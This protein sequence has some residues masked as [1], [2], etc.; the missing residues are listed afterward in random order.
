MSE[1]RKLVEEV[2]SDTSVCTEPGESL[3]AGSVAFR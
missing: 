2:D 1:S 3:D